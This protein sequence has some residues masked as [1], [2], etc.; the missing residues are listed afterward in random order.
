MEQAKGES[1]VKHLNEQV[2]RERKSLKEASKNILEAESQI[3]KKHADIEGLKAASGTLLEDK[4][5]AEKELDLAKKNL[6]AL[7]MGTPL[8]TVQVC[9]SHSSLLT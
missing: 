7:A 5:Q 6:E 4:N 8:Y 1:D 3:A 2:N 9:V